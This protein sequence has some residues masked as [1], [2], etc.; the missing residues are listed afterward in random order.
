LRCAIQT[1]PFAIFQTAWV[2]I[3]SNEA[4]SLSF[5]GALSAVVASLERRKFPLANRL[6]LHVRIDIGV[7]V[8]A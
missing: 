5:L 8:D 1:N 6:D 4:A 7:V 2:E 3:E